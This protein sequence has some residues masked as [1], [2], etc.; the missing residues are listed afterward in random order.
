MIYMAKD[1]EK[2]K[3]RWKGIGAVFLF[4]LVI[5]AGAGIFYLGHKAGGGELQ[6]TFPSKSTTTTTTAFDPA[7]GLEVYVIDVGQGNCQLIRFAGQTLLYDGGEIG[8]EDDV[9]SFLRKIGVKRLDYV[10]ASH[11]HSDHVGGLAYGILEN[12]PVGEIILP[13]VPKDAVGIAQSYNAFLKAAEKKH[14]KEGTVISESKALGRVNFYLGGENG[15]ACKILGPTQ[16]V[17]NNGGFES[18]N[19]NSV[20]IQI[21]Y[22]DTSVLLT[23]DAEEK[24][25]MSLIESYNDTLKSNLFIAGHHGSATSNTPDF[26]N[27]VRPDMIAVSCGL[28]NSYGHPHAEVLAYCKTHSI[29]V[30]RTDY[31]GSLLFVSDGN[32]FSPYVITE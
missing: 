3:K 10:I 30:Y 21:R 25:E 19:N 8:R 31:Q 20:C 27:L 24:A 18:I 7:N 17:L 26:L 11:A 2:S 15:A 28:N 5:A 1:K 4:L 23:G 9:T 22:K 29:P 6:F 16:F 12:F 13:F 32:H 14:N